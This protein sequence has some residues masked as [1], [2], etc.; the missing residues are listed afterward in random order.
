MTAGLVPD[1]LPLPLNQEVVKVVEVAV[2][3]AARV[4]SSVER[5]ATCQ[6]NVP[7][8]EEEAVEVLATSV[9]RKDTWPGSVLLEAVEIISAGIADRFVK[10]NLRFFNNFLI[11]GGT[12]GF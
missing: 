8:E 1:L 3:A 2:V 12:H 10:Y 4:A 11:L 7:V 9:G 5:M 6:G